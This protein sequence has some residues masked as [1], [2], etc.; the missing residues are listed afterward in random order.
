MLLAQPGRRSLDQCCRSFNLNGR[1]HSLATVQCVLLFH[2]RFRCYL[3]LCCTTD[4]L[5]CGCLAGSFFLFIRLDPC[6]GLFKGFA[7]SD[8]CGRPQLRLR[9]VSFHV[10]SRQQ[11]PA[12]VWRLR[13]SWHL[14]A[15]RLIVAQFPLTLNTLAA[16]VIGRNIDDFLRRFCR[17]LESFIGA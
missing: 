14:Q 12:L 13:L 17:W 2:G 16:R 8:R 9:Q 3:L 1:L 4:C 15:S 5:P 10:R 11:V 7:H 6:Q